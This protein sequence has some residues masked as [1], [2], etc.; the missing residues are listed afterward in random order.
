MP[1]LLVSRRERKRPALF[2]GFGPR[3]IVDPHRRF[4]ETYRPRRQ[5]S[6]SPR[7]RHCLTLED[8][9]YWL[10]RNVVRNLQSTLHK[11]P[12]ELRSHLQIRMREITEQI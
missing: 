10:S 5:G 1:L 3:R 8:V 6:S 9:I 2:W 12:E 7:R 11:V 4:G